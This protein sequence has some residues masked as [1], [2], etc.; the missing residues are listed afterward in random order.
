MKASWLI[1]RRSR[2]LRSKE[3]KTSGLLDSPITLLRRVEHHLVSKRNRSKWKEKC[4]PKECLYLCPIRLLSHIRNMSTPV[5]EKQ[6]EKH[7]PLP[8]YIAFL[9]QNLMQRNSCGRLNCYIA[10]V[11]VLAMDIIIREIQRPIS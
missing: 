7:C 10:I 9:K 1:Y 2:N 4:S 6:R 11:S 8:L 3:L 5:T